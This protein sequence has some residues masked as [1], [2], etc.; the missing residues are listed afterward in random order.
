MMSETDRNRG[1]AVGD[2]L[3][4]LRRNLQIIHD[5]VVVAALALRYQNADRDREIAQVL[6]FLVGNRLADQIEQAG[7]LLAILQGTEPSH[8]DEE[9]DLY[10][11]SHEVRESVPWWPPCVSR[12]RWS[13]CRPSRSGRTNDVYVLWTMGLDELQA[14][15]S[16]QSSRPSRPSGEYFGISGNNEDSR[17]K[18]SRWSARWTGHL[19]AS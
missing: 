11:D 10:D 8:R 2:D 1:R 19:S 13:F 5:G 17:R 15:P 14:L 6:E 9:D 4:L 18:R 12:L 3:R 16:W 7:K